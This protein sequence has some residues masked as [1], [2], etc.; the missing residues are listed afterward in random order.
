MSYAEDPGRIPLTEPSAS[1]PRVV[2]IQNAYSL[3]CRTF[4]AH[5]AECCFEEEVSLIAYSP[6]AMGLLTVMIVI[7]S[8][9]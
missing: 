3:T 4:D 1:L 5:L 7:V 8:K 6:L 9:T 2:S